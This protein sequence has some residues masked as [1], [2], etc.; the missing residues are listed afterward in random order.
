M[1]IEDKYNMTKNEN[2]F[3]AKRNVV[4]NIYNSIKLEGLKITFA[5]TYAIYYKAYLKEVHISDVNT[6]L[7]LKNA[8]KYVLS[9]IDKPITLEY[10]LD[11]HKE[12]AN[13]EALA[14]GVLR[15]GGV[16]IGGTD[17]RPPI[18]VKEEV[19]EKLKEFEQIQGCT[20]RSIERML[21]MMKQQLF[22]DGNK[23]TA[24]LIAN[25]DMISHGKGIITI[26]EK[27]IHTFGELLS[28]FY[29]Y[30]KKDDL[31]KF[32]FEKG[33]DGIVFEKDISQDELVLE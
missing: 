24:M 26:P 33:I 29:S 8:W 19:I 16:G 23:R 17:Y 12:V 20:E 18:P 2:I 21:W 31:K 32:I 4:G 7:N 1:H 25:K 15:N 27:D 13:D 30:V 6:V 5:E 9:N 22:W 28:D 3:L 11:V 14:W 10:I